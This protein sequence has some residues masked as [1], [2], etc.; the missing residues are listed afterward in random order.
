MTFFQPFWADGWIC[1]QRWPYEVIDPAWLQD[2]MQAAGRSVMMSGM[3]IRAT[4]ETGIYLDR[5]DI[6]RPCH[7]LFG[8]LYANYVSWW[9]EFISA[10]WFN[11]SSHEIPGMLC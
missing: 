11:P 4:S 5:W 8:P 2:V 7:R 6:H 10:R 9:Q 3:S 1:T